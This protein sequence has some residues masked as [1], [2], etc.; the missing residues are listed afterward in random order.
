MPVYNAEATLGRM[1]DSIRNQTFSD[2][3]LIAV[4]DGS[5]DKSG[6]KLDKYSTVD[7][8]IR[9]IH[10]DNGGVASARKSGLEN[11][12]GEYIINADSDDWIE[13]TMLE[14]MI[15]KADADNADIV[16][17]DYYIDRNNRQT[18]KKRQHLD[19]FTSLN[20]LKAFYTGEL[21]GALW[22]K[23]ISKKLLDNIKIT[24]TEGIDYCED[25]LFLTKILG[26]YDVKIS[27]I[28]K[29]YYHYVVRKDSISQKFTT[30]TYKSFRRFHE[31]ATKTL[32]KKNIPHT[33]EEDDFLVCFM[34]RFY[35]NKKEVREEYTKIKPKIKRRYSLRWRLGF[36]CIEWGQIKL[37]HLL[38]TF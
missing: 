12:T 24:F 32:S 29:A 19:N 7:K 27:Y 17:T 9:V 11:A 31:E 1:I 16:I 22:N 18:E 34:N 35:K 4:D 25:L 37:A 38:I 15:T 5:T 14:E 6:E 28:P 26:S 3:E 13:Q 23:L 10:K 30:K 2:W 8:R 36:K 20:V 33:F 21:F